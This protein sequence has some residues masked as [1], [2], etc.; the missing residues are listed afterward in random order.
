[1]LQVLSSSVADSLAFLQNHGI[2]GFENVEGTINFIR[3]MDRV[4]DIMNSKSRLVS[5]ARSLE[6]KK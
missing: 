3:V 5:L 1:M 6:V 2:Q 4:F